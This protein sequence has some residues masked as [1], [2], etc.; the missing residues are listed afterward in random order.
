MDRKDEAQVRDIS[1][2]TTQYIR[3]NKR[4]NRHEKSRDSGRIQRITKGRKH[5][6]K[7]KEYPHHAHEKQVG[8]H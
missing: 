6:D 1:K 8:K 2:K 7:K 4:S 5:Q 3:D